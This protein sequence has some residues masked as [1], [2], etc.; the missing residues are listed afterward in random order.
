M[1]GPDCISLPAHG[2]CHI[3]LINNTYVDSTLD[4]TQKGIDKQHCQWII[5]EDLHDC[6]HGQGTALVPQVG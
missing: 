1:C 2:T 6:V 5:C 3:S 4:P